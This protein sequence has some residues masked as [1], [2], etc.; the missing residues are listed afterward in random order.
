MFSVWAFYVLTFYGVI[1]LRKDNPNLHRSYKVPMYP[2]IPIV[3]MCG[4]LFVIINQLLFAG[5]FNRD[6]SIGSVVITLLGLPVYNYFNK[7]KDNDFG[8]EEIV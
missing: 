5:S 6:M 7:L 4:G 1:K 8:S 3:A 2:F